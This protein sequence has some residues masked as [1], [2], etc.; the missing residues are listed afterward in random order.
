M[1]YSSNTNQNNIELMKILNQILDDIRYHKETI[2]QNDLLLHPKLELYKLNKELNKFINQI[3]LELGYKE[4]KIFIKEFN[5]NFLH[6]KDWEKENN[7]N[8][9]NIKNIKIK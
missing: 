1:K 9:K 6:H 8:I 4:L 5:I 2:K 7:I 3:L